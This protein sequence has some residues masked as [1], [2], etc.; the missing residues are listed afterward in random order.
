MGWTKRW[1]RRLRAVLRRDATERDLDEEMAFH[2]EMQT[3]ENLRAGMAPEEARRQAALAFGGA[4][5]FKEEVRDARRLGWVPGLSL[6]LRLGARMLAKSPG[7]TLVGG[8]GM[9]VAIA[10]GAGA[11]SFFYGSLFTPLPLDEGGRIVA[12]ENWDTEANNEER[13]SLHDFVAWRGELRS[14][15]ELAAFRTVGRNLVA[16]GAQAEPVTVAEMTASGFRVA[17]VPPLLGRY[18]VDDDERAGAAPVVVLGHD[19]WRTRFAGDPE[20]VGRTLHLG[21]T[22]HTVVGVMPPGFAFP[23]KHRYWT[24]LRA[25]PLHHP[26]GEGPELFVFGRLAPGATPEQA[27]AELT[28]V[29]RRTAAA[30]PDTHRH[31]RPRVLPYAYPL[32]DIQ[33]VGLWEVGMMQLVVSLLLVVV[34]VNVAVLV[35]ARTATR[36]GEIAVRTALGASRRRIVAQL[37]LEALVLSGGAAA[38]GLALAAVGLRQARR[39]MEHEGG[40]APFWIDY[41]LVPATVLYAVGMAVLAAVLVGVVPALQAT[42]RRVQGSLRQL[43]GGTGLQLGRTWTV[44]IAVQV[45]LAVSALPVAVAMGWQEMRHGVTEPAFA[46]ERFLAAGLLMDPEPPSDAPA[47]ARER[48]FSARYGERLSELARRL[49]ADPEVAGVTFASAPPG[50][51]Q[52]A[53]LEVEGVPAPASSPAGH[54]VVFN[55]VAPGFFGVLGVPVLAGRGLASGDGSEAATAVVVNRT[56]A[57]RVLGGGDPVGRR[58]R[59]AAMP[60][61]A[62][63]GAVE[64]GR[65]YEV[66]GV[67][68]DL[69]ANRLDGDV[70]QPGVYHAVAAGRV[71]PLLLAVRVRA[72]T[73][74]GFTARLREVAAALDPALRLHGVQPLDALDDQRATVFRL[75]AAVLALVM[76]AV[77]LLSA[78]GIYALMSFTVAQRRRE[79]GIRAALG[80][81]PRRLLAGVFSRAVGQLAVGLGG[82]VVAAALL[83]RAAGGEL[84]GGKAAVLLPAVAAL[85]LG[86]GLLAA[87]G[88]A[89]RGLRVQPMEALRA[90]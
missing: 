46:A 16:P 33:D 54:A 31:L 24:A 39:L 26:R 12:L 47:E 4:E 76:A 64:T 55:Q 45:A 3:R 89:R 8:L 56:F 51:E 87:L 61:W 19:V 9:A 69:H 41:G 62:D 36:R 20:V 13:R 83:D 30:F 35:Y 14:V 80:A 63:A 77:L 72:G 81:D 25:D 22:A 65:W 27:Q 40:G 48:A 84:L 57:R 90:E 15:R 52:P 18:L 85:M 58:I 66:V 17:R 50:D 43:G 60:A 10:I 7:L 44:L 6:D 38:A 49:E 73:P 68:E 75:V 29:G 1:H 21:S 82:G 2:L 5:R 67:V 42:G 78:A 86:A 74:A 79:I 28:A 11:F 59:Y 71:H 37:F 88:P 34:A 32:L 53:T 23:V 70:V